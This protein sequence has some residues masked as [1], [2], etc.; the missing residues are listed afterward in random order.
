MKT[1]IYNGFTAQVVYSEQ[2]RLYVGDVLDIGNDVVCFHGGSDEE[3][4]EAFK[5]VIDLYVE[6]KQNN[7][8]PCTA[9]IMK[10]IRL[11][12]PQF[13]KVKVR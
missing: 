11:F 2:D 3:L 6:S 7:K 1:M 13:R 9:A 10:C 5:G 4:E 8:H 12:T